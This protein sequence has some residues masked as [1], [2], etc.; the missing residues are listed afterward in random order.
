MSAP[1]CSA[2][3]RRH[4]CGGYERKSS[5]ARRIAGGAEN[6]A[7]HPIPAVQNLVFAIKRIEADPPIAGLVD[8]G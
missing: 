1:L 7:R 3:R 8:A 2:P 6:S 5:G 4:R